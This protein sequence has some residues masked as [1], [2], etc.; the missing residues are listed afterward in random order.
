MGV[1]GVDFALSTEAKTDKLIQRLKDGG[2]NVIVDTPEVMVFT[3]SNG[4]VIPESKLAIHRSGELAGQVETI[5][6]NVENNPRMSVAKFLDLQ[7][8]ATKH[9]AR[10]KADE[11]YQR[12]REMS[13][14]E[15]E[16]DTTIEILKEEGFVEAETPMAS[17]TFERTLDDGTHE[18][19]NLYDKH[20]FG[21]MMYLRDGKR[22]ESFTNI[23]DYNDAMRPS[24]WRRGMDRLKSALSL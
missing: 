3:R 9:R 21:V 13:S 10:V 23:W 4:D 15:L 14:Q 24:L 11:R 22:D 17:Y 5:F 16:L 18:I 7:D 19:V 1:L 20:A 8:S 12:R 6:D 2:F